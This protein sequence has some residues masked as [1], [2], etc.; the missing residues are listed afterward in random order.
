MAV[1]SKKILGV[2]PARFSSS[3]FPGKP[4]ADIHGKP[5]IWWVYK[6]AEKS[7]LLSESIIATE[8]ERITEVCEKLG[9]PY[10]MT[11]KTHP[12][13]T[14]RLSEVARKVPADIYI[15][16]QGDEPLID[17]RVIDSAVSP[18]I[19]DTSIQVLNLMSE[20]VHMH[21]IVSSTIPMVVVNHD[22]EAIF[23]SRLPIPFPKNPG[24]KYFK[25][26][27]VYGFRPAALI[28]FGDLPQGN[29]EQYEE[30][31]LLRFLENH[32]P[33]KMILVKSDNIAVD[34]PSDLKLVQEIIKKK[35]KK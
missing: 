13:G 2:I 22:S 10:I 34:T 24:A 7:K 18:M 32:I 25:Q 20:I 9:L 26:V 1:K 30:I 29:I 19:S 11:S 27:C 35:L 31:E 4:L 16:I 28:K 21:E 8:D 14:D 33:I 3:R 12:T 6:Q 17:P 5:M 15:N 23:M